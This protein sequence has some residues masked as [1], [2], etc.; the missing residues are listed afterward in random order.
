MSQRHDLNA[1]YTWIASTSAKLAIVRSYSLRS[2]VLW[3]D[4]KREREPHAE[5]LAEESGGWHHTWN[6][7]I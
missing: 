4:P 5:R 1:R 2:A 7:V 6:R 3:D